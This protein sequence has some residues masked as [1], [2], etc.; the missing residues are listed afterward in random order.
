MALRPQIAKVAPQFLIN[1]IRLYWKWDRQVSHHT[2]FFGAAA[3]TNIL[4]AELFYGPAAMLLLTRT[5]HFLQYAGSS[6]ERLNMR[7]VQ[8]LQ[9]H[10]FCAPDLDARLVALEQAAL[11]RLLRGLEK[12]NPATY[13]LAVYQ[14]DWLLAR[15]GWLCRDPFAANPAAC[16]YQEVLQQVRAEVGRPIRF[17]LQSDRERIGR[18]LIGLLPSAADLWTRSNA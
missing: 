4:L 9:S 17:A 10:R 8:G 2:R 11:E 18:T 14:M 16:L 6:L 15:S 5:R 3:L 7:A 13:S 1:R 12:T